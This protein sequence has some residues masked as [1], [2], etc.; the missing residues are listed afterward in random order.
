MA[1]GDYGISPLEHT[2]GFATF[3]N[4]GKLSKPYGILELVN[5]KGDLVYSRDRDEP[6]APQVIARKVVEQLNQMMQRVVTDGTAK[7]AALDFTHAVGK[8][9]TTL[10]LQ[11]RLVCRLHR[12]LR[13]ERLARQ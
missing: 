4:G 8:T 10:E 9:G 3:A 11:G 1:L 6:E 12:T 13:R 5:S 2:G 7:A